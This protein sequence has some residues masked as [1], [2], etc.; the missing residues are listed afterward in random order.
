MANFGYSLKGKHTR[1]VRD[2]TPEEFMRVI[3]TAR[4]L[5]ARQLTGEHCKIF[6]GRTL[7]MV[8]Q[9]PSLRTVV[10][11][12]VAMNQL[13]GSAIYLGPDQINLGERE[14]VEDVA[15]VLSGYVDAIMVRVFGH[16]LIE[17]LAKYSRVPVING[18]SDFEHPCQIFG[19]MLTILERKGR[20]QGLKLC[21]VGD[22]NNVA[23][24]LAFA[25]ARLGL[26][27]TI[28]SPVGY[29]LKP[30]VI[31]MALA[32]AKTFCT[33]SKV[34]QF[35]DLKEAA[36]DADIVYTDVW[37]SMGQEAEKVERQKK[38]KG[39]II[40]QEL[41]KVTKPDAMIL[42]CLPAHYGEEI[43]ADMQLDPRS[44]VYPQAENRLHAQKGL[45]AM[46]MR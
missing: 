2:F 44:A 29:E 41:L 26:N 5:K 15:N 31:Q 33:G 22:G 45:L 25:A 24:S 19:D 32:D 14:T 23:N 16:H 28:G 4:E 35:H 36:R 17:E 46:V 18:L 1:S 11:F 13:G 37:A 21:F 42:H 6:E 20:L 34:E 43:A 38:F 10:S 12:Q 9:K 3:Y 30:E 27:F 8:F 39:Y 40:D 7:G